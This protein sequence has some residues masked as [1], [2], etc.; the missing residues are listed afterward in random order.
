MNRT[1]LSGAVFAAALLLAFAAPL[2][3]CTTVASS[4][5]SVAT[6]LS[7][8]S[9][10]Q[11]TTFADATLAATAA[12]NFADA[13]VA[14]GKLDKGTLVQIRALNEG[15]HSAWVDLSNANA[16]GKSLSFASFNAALDAWN[17]Y[18][19]VKGISH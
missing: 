5:A 8:S 11:V 9:P 12:T 3:G 10:T 14:S 17:A 18:A 2:G 19:T 15:V 4:V 16:A 1:R 7:S 13:A 6:S